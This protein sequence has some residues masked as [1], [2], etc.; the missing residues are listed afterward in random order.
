MLNNEAKNNLTILM[1]AGLPFT[2][3][4]MVVVFLGLF[5]IKHFFSGNDYLVAFLFVW[6]AIFWAV[7]QPLFRRRIA[8]VKHSLENN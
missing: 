8:R 5:L 7:Y 3:L 1:K 6:L 2:L 4:G